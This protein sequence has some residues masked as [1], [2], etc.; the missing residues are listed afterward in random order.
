MMVICPVVC[1]VLLIKYS[2]FFTKDCLF[3]HTPK[4]SGIWNL[5]L[6]HISDIYLIQFDQIYE[7]GLRCNIFYS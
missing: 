1:L 6:F 7:F 2:Q 4:M 3:L 5:Y